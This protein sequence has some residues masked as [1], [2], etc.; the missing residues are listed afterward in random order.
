[1]RLTSKVVLLV[2]G[3]LLFLTAASSA[4]TKIRLATLLPR[5][6]SHYQVLE[7]MGQQWRS[8]SGG[9][10]TLTIYADGTM[11]GEAETVQRMRIGQLQ[12]ATL[13][14]AGLSEI[15]PSVGALEKIPM[16]YRSLDE[17][18][19]VRAHMQA[20]GEVLRSVLP[21]VA[22]LSTGL[23]LITYIPGLTTVLPRLFG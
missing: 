13:S 21:V 4:Q 8:A 17:V 22:V 6:S 12:A 18:D 2:Q 5:G 3:C 10:I 1:M 16:V 9:N 11:G 19:Y 15:D 20:E 14:A 7:T 23:L